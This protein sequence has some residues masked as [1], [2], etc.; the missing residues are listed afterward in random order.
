[1]LYGKCESSSIY[2]VTLAFE[3]QVDLYN[4]KSGISTK[5]IIILDIPS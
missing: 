5:S 2:N 1:M 3:Q 4:L